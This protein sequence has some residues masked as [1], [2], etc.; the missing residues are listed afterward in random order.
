MDILK[1]VLSP[2]IKM[3][4]KLYQDHMIDPDQYEDL[5]YL[6]ESITL[7]LTEVV[8]AHEVGESVREVINKTLKVE[9]EVE[10]SDRRERYETS[11][12]TVQ[13]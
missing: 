4:L 9:G 1:D 7:A 2:A 12:G 13:Q 5:N 8:V 10:V 11:I 6:H 3:S